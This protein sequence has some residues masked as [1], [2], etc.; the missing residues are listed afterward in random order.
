M[1][2]LFARSPYIVE[3][4]ESSVVGS[5]IEL[6]YYYS[7]T[8][9]PT[10][11]Q[12]IIK[13]L[14][15]SSNDLKM[16][17]DISP[18]TREYLK[19]TTRQT[20]IGSAVSTGVAANNHNQMVKLDVKRYKETSAANYTLLDTTTYYCMDGYGYYS[21]GS[22]PQ[23]TSLEFATDQTASLPQ[24]T[25]YYKYS[26]ASNA[27]S[28]EADR[29]GMLCVLGGAPLVDIKYTN[30]SSGATNI[31]TNPFA[32]TDLYDVPTVW[33]D[34]YADGNKLEIWDNLGGGSPTLYGTWY[35]KPQEEC[36]YTPVMVDFVNQMGAWQ[37]EWF[38]KASKNN[39]DVD[40]KEYNL[41]QTNSLSYNTLEGQ[42]KGFNNNAQEKI[43]CNTGHVVEGY[44]ETIQQ[45]LLSEK[46]LLDSLPVI[47]DKKSIE[48][49]KSINAEK[50]INYNLTFKYAFDM[51]NSV[52]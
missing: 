34:Y 18:Y 13:K 15:P 25:Y 17:Y 20:V 10:N 35:F 19:F 11:P 46:I 14:I 1:N 3:V 44:S 23:L 49:I 6:F 7:G 4:D 39:I 8:S 33:Y 21:E 9:V 26:A 50:P 36:K 2:K 38:Y 45:I 29:A 42:I 12:Y 47:V 28:V 40:Q 24:G 37:R 41:M 32:A 51:I 43:T 31:V 16:Y 30:L 5:K 22:N 52:I 27:P 48:K